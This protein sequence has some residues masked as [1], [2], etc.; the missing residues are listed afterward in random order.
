MEWHRSLFDVIKK[1]KEN[2]L[3]LYGA[4]FWGCLGYELFAMFDLAPICYCDDDPDKIGIKYM[5]RPVYSLEKCAAEHKNAVFIICVDDNVRDR[6]IRQK[7]IRNLKKFQLYSSSSEIHLAYYVFLLDTGKQLFHRN[8]DLNSIKNTDYKWSELNKIVILNHMSNSGSFY[9]EQIMDFHPNILC[10]PLSGPFERVYQKRLRYLEGEELLIEIMAQM[11]GYFHSKFEDIYCV[12]QHHFDGYCVDKDGKFIEELL[13]SPVQFAVKLV[14]Q[15]RGEKVLRLKSYGTF[16]KILFAAYNNCLARG[17]ED[18]NW[19]L[20]HMHEVNFSPDEIVK[21]FNEG[22]FERIENLII[23]REPVQHCYSWIKRFVIQQKNINAADK[24]F[25][26]VIRSELGETLEKRTELNNVKVIRF[27]DLKNSFMGTVHSLC[28][29]LGIPFNDSMLQTTTNG[30]LIYFPANTKEG[31][32]YITGADKTAIKNKVFIDVFPVWDEVR[33]NMLYANFKNAYGYTSVV[34]NIKYFEKKD[35][36]IIM[37]QKFE[38]VD[39]VEDLLDRD[40][41]KNL[42][43]NKE[44]SDIYMQYYEH[45]NDKIEYYECIQPVEV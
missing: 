38:F 32:K 8:I 29:W 30:R 34:P 31:V 12:G 36:E 10:L 42:N 5:G 33:L 43:I 13:I 20:Y 44:V 28:R 24:H 16:L 6:T 17:K 45:A 21:Q 9:L 1:G 19:L 3:V 2:G 23:I 18:N 22:E 11:T 41:Q 39:L 40:L 25:L 26:S 14:E 37:E 15:F 4:G 7:M 27:E 35:Y